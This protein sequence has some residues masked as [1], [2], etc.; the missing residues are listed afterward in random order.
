MSVD[1]RDGTWPLAIA[2]G[3]AGQERLRAENDWSNSIINFLAA[4][5][6]HVRQ[7]REGSGAFIGCDACD[8][9]PQLCYCSANLYQELAGNIHF[10][11]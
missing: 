11:L 6:A 8:P 5:Q 4:V 7:R 2:F 3:F 10:S 1:L 9:L